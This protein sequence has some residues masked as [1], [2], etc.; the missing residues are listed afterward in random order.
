MWLQEKFEFHV[1][2]TW[3]ALVEVLSCLPKPGH[4]FLM[5][6][7]GLRKCLTLSTSLEALC[8]TA[9][10]PDVPTVGKKLGSFSL[11]QMWSCHRFH[12]QS[13]S[14]FK[15][16][17][18]YFTCPPLPASWSFYEA[19]GR[20]CMWKCCHI[21]MRLTAMWTLSHM[22]SKLHRCYPHS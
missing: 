12:W 9:S 10:S 17:C 5:A 20:N 22:S 8:F 1:G 7:Q 19:Q 18:N 16:K 4:P 6:L 14:N 13:S 3:T 2:I 15:R 21:C 11:C